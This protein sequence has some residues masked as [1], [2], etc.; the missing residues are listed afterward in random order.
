MG[1]LLNLNAESGADYVSDDTTGP[2]VS[3]KSSA[4]EGVAIEFA[5]T[6]AGSATV[7]VARLNTNSTASA[8]IFEL[9][10][11][12][13]VSATT[14]LFTTAASAGSGAIR[15]KYGDNYGW[16]PVLRDSAVTAAPRG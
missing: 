1:N 15:V 11:Q 14:I 4:T 16:I 7:A 6:V 13:F 10:N 3:F 12:S 2:G 9:T 5:R 8:P